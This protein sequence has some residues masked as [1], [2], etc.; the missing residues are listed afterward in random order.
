ML[1]D[2]NTLANGAFIE[3]FADIAEHSP[4]VA[5]RAASSRPFSCVA[6]MVDAFVY[7]MHTATPQDQLSL[8][9]AHPDLAGR[10][11]IAGELTNDSQREQAGA[12]LDQ[13]TQDEML[14]FISLNQ[15][16]LD[17][18]G[19]PF[20]FAVKGANKLQI[21][22]AFEQRIN[23]S[24]DQEFAIALTQV[25]RIIQFRLEDIVDGT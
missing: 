7:V 20:I 14:R 3:R 25:A 6:S 16:Y 17:N 5:E 1:S 12:G 9:Q 10:A 13:L 8:I 22:E 23:N 4:W 24:R 21:L 18:F 11:A 15:R 19:F 2:V